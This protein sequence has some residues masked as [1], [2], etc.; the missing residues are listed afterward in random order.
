VVF[1]GVGAGGGVADLT[2]LTAGGASLSEVL[3]MMVI[4]FLVTNIALATNGIWLKVDVLFDT[5]PQIVAWRGVACH[6]SG[7]LA[8]DAFA[9]R[10]WF[11]VVAFQR[12]RLGRIAGIRSCAAAAQSAPSGPMGTV[13]A[14]KPKKAIREDLQQEPGSPATAPSQVGPE[15][16]LSGRRYTRSTSPIRMELITG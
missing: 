4:A 3:S 8:K 11:H 15:V 14:K 10:R 2:T 9:S 16:P 13:A 5:V 7:S 12:S 6:L 1:C